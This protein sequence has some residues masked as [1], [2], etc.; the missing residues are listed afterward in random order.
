MQGPK[1]A[2]PTSQDL[3]SQLCVHGRLL[4]DTLPWNTDQCVC[5]CTSVCACG[6]EKSDTF[7]EGQYR[8]KQS[9]PLS[10]GKKPLLLLTRD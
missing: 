2:A 5:V 4:L 6:F 9:L 7:L 8:G 10:V 1:H 3:D